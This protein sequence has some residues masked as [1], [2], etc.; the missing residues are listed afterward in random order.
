MAATPRVF[1]IA[2]LAVMAHAS[3]AQS[4]KDITKEH[5]LQAA[6]CDTEIELSLGNIPLDNVG[7]ITIPL[8]KCTSIYLGSV[9]GTLVTPLSI[10]LSIEKLSVECIVP[11]LDYTVLKIF[12]GTAAASL[13]VSGASLG[14]TLVI[15]QGGTQDLP[16]SIALKGTSV[17]TGDISLRLG[18]SIATDVL[19][20]LRGAIELALQTL[21]P[22][23]VVSVLD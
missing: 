6:L 10:E 7:T 3:F 20:V 2:W 13:G 19:N 8:I 18:G 9:E 14:T 1:I 22:S 17:S 12:S 4:C 16:Q 11:E 23:K 15:T 21:L 5:G